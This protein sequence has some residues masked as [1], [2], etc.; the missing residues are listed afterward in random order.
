[1]SAFRAF[2]GNRAFFRSMFSACKTPLCTGT[3]F[4]FF[5]VHWGQIGLSP[6]SIPLLQRAANIVDTTL[7]ATPQSSQRCGTKLRR[8]PLSSTSDL[9]TRSPTL[10]VRNSMHTPG[11]AVLK[12]LIALGGFALAALPVSAQRISADSLKNGHFPQVVGHLDAHPDKSIH[13]LPSNGSQAS[14]LAT[15]AAADAKPADPPHPIISPFLKRWSFPRII[16][17]MILA[18]SNSETTPRM[19]SVTLPSGSFR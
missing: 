8:L 15:A 7:A 9:T 12:S 19:P 16:R 13:R 2:F 11:Y 10:T 3:G 1:M 5:A 17:S 4:S 14:P 6:S 18:R